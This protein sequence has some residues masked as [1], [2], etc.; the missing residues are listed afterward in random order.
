MGCYI[1]Y[2]AAHFY[3]RWELFVPAAVIVGMGAAPLWASKSHYLNL[4]G[5]PWL[6]SMYC[7]MPT[8]T[9]LWLSADNHVIRKIFCSI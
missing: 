1:M 2:M 4:V 5:R 3:A 6:C 7:S 8:D 9:V